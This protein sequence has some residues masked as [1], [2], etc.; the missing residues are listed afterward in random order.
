MPTT[1][2]F[3]YG[4]LI[5]EGRLRSLTGRTFPRRPA[6]LDGYERVTP[7]GGYPYVVPKPGSTVD[8]WL[9]EDVDATSLARLD[10]YEDEGRLYWRRTAAVHVDGVAVGCEVY[11]GNVEALRPPS[12][13]R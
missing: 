12:P 4:T 6:R 3:V 5:D 10:A 1:A 11:V 13:R 8:G 2:L 7:P 9:V